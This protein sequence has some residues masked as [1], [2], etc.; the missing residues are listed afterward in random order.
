MKTKSSFAL[1]G[2]LSVGAWSSWPRSYDLSALPFSSHDVLSFAVSLD[3]QRAV[4]TAGR[5]V[6]DLDLYSVPMNGQGDP[7]RLNLIDQEVEGY[8]HLIT[9]DSSRVIYKHRGGTG[10][11]AVP[12]DGGAA[13]IVLDTLGVG[14]FDPQFALGGSHVVFGSISSSVTLNLWSLP[15]DGSPRTLLASTPSF[16]G[17]VEHRVVAN[18]ELVLYRVDLSVYSVP[19]DGSAAPVFLFQGRN[20]AFWV[21]PAGD[22]AVYLG[23]VDVFQMSTDGSGTP[24]Q[25]NP[26]LAAGRSCDW[27]VLSPDGERVV[28]YADQDH[29]ERYELYSVALGGGA[30]VKLN[31][32][33]MP[34]GRIFDWEITP[35]DESVVYTADTEGDGIVELFTAPLAG[36][37][38]PVK[39]NA[40][41]GPTAD[42]GVFEISPDGARVAFVA[43]LQTDEAYEL[44]SV[45]IDGSAPPVQL[46]GTSFPPANLWHRKQFHF[47]PDSAFLVYATDG[48]GVPFG[49][50]GEPI[51]LYAVP[52]DGSS[53]SVPLSGPM[54]SGG[55]VIAGSGSNY[56]VFN[57][58]GSRIA[59]VADQDLNNTFELYGSLLPSR[60]R[61]Q[62]AR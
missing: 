31:D 4:F 24:L 1:I 26:P 14:V 25:L 17:D 46:S 54:P 55:S 34:G 30:A 40:P 13:P 15:I 44:Y 51:E 9:P 37:S 3:G 5:D 7:V 43:D 28:Y 58:R 21:T 16:N 42:I 50:V 45:P 22:R 48:D 35:D 12:I 11:Q 20:G 8:S 47:A 23:A 41:L 36:G 59:Y 49:F 38:A 52:A 57:A 10:L 19:A 60:P 53:E 33:L 39:L 62:R 32:E 27:L 61:A 2:L 6:F 29:D 56:F 18:G